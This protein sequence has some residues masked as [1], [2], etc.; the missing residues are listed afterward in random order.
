MSATEA[1]AAPHAEFGAAAKLYPP[2]V[3]PPEKALRLPAFLATF[4]R[5]PLLAVPRVVYE[6]PLFVYRRSATA[7]LVWVTD[8]A[9]IERILLDAH[10]DFPKTALERRVFQATLGQGILTASGATWRWQRRTAAPMFRHQ[11]LLGYL[12]VMTGAAQAQLERWRATG[13]ARAQ[14]IEQA[15]VTPLSRLEQLGGGVR[16][17]EDPAGGM[18]SGQMANA[19]GGGRPSRDGRRVADAPASRDRDGQRRRIGRLAGAAAG[20][21]RS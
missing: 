13:P 19:V 2:T 6:E 5:N 1:T 17:A 4:V 21:A 20:R 8:P 10:N 14:P 16:A 3:V 12:P 15:L 7:G 11:D 18:A 9:L